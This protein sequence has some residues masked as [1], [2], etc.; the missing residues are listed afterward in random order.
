MDD[1]LTIETPRARFRRLVAG[2]T[3]IVCPGVVNALTARAAE[4]A[5]F[6][7]IYA[8]GG[9]IA[10]ALLGFPDIGLLTMTELLDIDRKITHSVSVPV[11]ADIDTGYGGAFNV[12]RT[13]RE[14]EAAG[15]AGVQIEDQVNPKRCG[16]FDDKEV[17]SL[18]EMLERLIAAREARKDPDLVI[19]AR[20]DSLATHGVAEAIRRANA[21]V[22]AGADVVFVEAP[23]EE[24]DVRRIPLEVDAP[25]L[26]N[27]VEGGR[28]PALPPMEL[29]AMGYRI[30]LYANTVLRAAAAASAAALE[31]L[32]RTGETKELMGSILSWEDRQK[33]VAL[34]EWLELGE[35]IA[36]A[37]QRIAREPQD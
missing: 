15:L 1:V 21:F 13:V 28:T 33:L 17:V 35:S 9:G 3:L 16:H 2:S 36:S 24:D 4:A 34:D 12:Y 27:I 11:L 22:E 20:T 30:A 18:S 14:F 6:E 23:E 29:E 10:N 31:V 26:I 37:A 32:G 25:V 7:L 8:T 19:V 5:G